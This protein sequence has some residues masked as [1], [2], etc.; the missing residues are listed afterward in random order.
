MKLPSNVHVDSIWKSYEW[1]ELNLQCLQN[2]KMDYWNETQSLVFN[3]I[4]SS[5]NLKY[6]IKF[7]SIFI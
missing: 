3:T 1:I 5:C 2:F 7:C 4:L 6:L